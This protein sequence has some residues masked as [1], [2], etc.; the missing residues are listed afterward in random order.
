MLPTAI[1]FAKTAYTIAP[2]SSNSFKRAERGLFGGKTK[3][4]G[5]STSHSVS[6]A[7]GKNSKFIS[8]HAQEIMYLNHIKRPGELG[9]LTFKARTYIQ[10]PSMQGFA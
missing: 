1:R 3:L 9:F 4:F 10:Q 8:M 2:S 7:E 6:P 5:L